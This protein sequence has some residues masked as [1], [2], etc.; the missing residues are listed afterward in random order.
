MSV[1]IDFEID[2]LRNIKIVNI[3]EC[4]ANEQKSSGIRQL[5]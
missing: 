3:N 4:I 2:F 5:W 1:E